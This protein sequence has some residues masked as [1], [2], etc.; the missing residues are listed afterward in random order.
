MH[1]I[2]NQIVVKIKLKRDTRLQK[3]RA[4]LDFSCNPSKN[5]ALFQFFGLKRVKC[6]TFNI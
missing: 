4:E 2:D 6:L 5:S 3:K 1:S